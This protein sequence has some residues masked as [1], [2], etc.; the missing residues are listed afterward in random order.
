MRGHRN[1][2]QRPEGSKIVGGLTVLG[3]G[4][5]FLLA[6]AGYIEA[7]DLVRLWPLI[8][9]A[10]GVSQLIGRQ[11]WGFL[12]IAIGLI[13]LG[14]TLDLTRFGLLDL[15][16]LWPVLLVFAGV[17]LIRQALERTPKDFA[18]GSPAVLRMFAI[19]GANV[20]KNG[21]SEFLGGDLTA[22]MGG[23]EVD[24]REA[25]MTTGEAVIDVLAI[26][27]GIDIQVPRDWEVECRV[28]PLLG[29]IGNRTEKP[30]ERRGRLVIR[31]VAIMGGVDVKY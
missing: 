5:A 24:L 3:V 4:I 15:W 26:W 11:L 17:N 16:G 29:G 20:R 12:W 22:V 30:E 13:L 31:G 19:M 25:T 2:N 18:P 14:N 10:I 28:L 8:L 27:G 21:S 9:V 6:R 1:G 23:C 7:D